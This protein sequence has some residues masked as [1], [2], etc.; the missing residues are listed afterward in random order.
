M[1]MVN[2]RYTGKHN[3]KN[4]VC[5]GSRHSLSSQSCDHMLRLTEDC[6]RCNGEF[7]GCRKSARNLTKTKLKAV[8]ELFR[9]SSCSGGQLWSQFDLAA[10]VRHGIVSGSAKLSRLPIERAERK[11]ECDVEVRFM[12]CALFICSYMLI[13]GSDTQCRAASVETSIWL[14]TYCA[15]TI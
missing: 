9:N 12:H 8:T 5:S 4:W 10:K 15:F 2:P 1:F 3:I 6:N 11:Q 7:T 13:Y 14:G